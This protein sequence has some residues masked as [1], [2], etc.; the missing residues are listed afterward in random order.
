MESKWKAEK[1]SGPHQRTE[2]YSF[3]THP[4]RANS[5]VKLF[6]IQRI[7]SLRL[8][9]DIQYHADSFIKDVILPDCRSAV[10]C[11]K[12]KWIVIYWREFSH[13][14]HPSSVFVGEN[15]TISVYFDADFLLARYPLYNTQNNCQK[16]KLRF[17]SV[18]GNKILKCNV[19]Q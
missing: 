12:A 10:I 19:F 4:L 11:K 13:N 2:E 14:E 9:G 8:E 18:F 5:G 7:L 17:V 6:W 16:L 15:N 3:S 1:V